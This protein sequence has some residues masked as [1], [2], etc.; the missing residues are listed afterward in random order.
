MDKKIQQS[1]SKQKSLIQ[2]NEINATLTQQISSIPRLGTD[3][4]SN[5]SN[6]NYSKNPNFSQK[7]GL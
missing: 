3:R 5:T 2:S 7:F 1:Q 6:S 4:F